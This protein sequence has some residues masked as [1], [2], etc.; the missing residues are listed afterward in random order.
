MICKISRKQRS[1]PLTYL[2]TNHS[3]I[4]AKKDIANLLAEIFSKNSSSPNNSQFLKIKPKAE[5]VKFHFKF[6]N[7]ETYKLFTLPEPM[8]SIKN[9]TI[10]LSVQTKYTISFKATAQRI[11]D[12]SSGGFP[13]YMDRQ[14][15][16]RCMET[17]DSYSH[18]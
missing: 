14:Q 13:Q 17:D 3:K 1:T 6:D 11:H 18:S 12:I 16:S 10:Q 9:P 4:T 7:L 5:K 8:D 15:I 2:S